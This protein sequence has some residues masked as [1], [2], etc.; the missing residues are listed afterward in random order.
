MLRKKFVFRVKPT[1]NC[2]GRRKVCSKWLNVPGI[3]LKL[4]STRVTGSNTQGEN[5]ASVSHCTRLKGTTQR[6][7]CK[8][9]EGA[10]A[11][12]SLTSMAVQGVA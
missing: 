7:A 1:G 3:G 5:L 10:E 6:Q 4:T 2:G 12:C 9:D 11:A 8:Q